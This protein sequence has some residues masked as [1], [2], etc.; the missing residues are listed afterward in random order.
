MTGT[1]GSSHNGSGNGHDKDE[2]NGKDVIEFPSLA[3]RDRIRKEKRAEEEKIRA[4]Y[5][6]QNKVPFFNVSKIPPATK[7]LFGAIFAVHILTL[8]FLDNIGQFDLIRTAGFTPGTFTGEA[9]W[10]WSALATP[11]SYIFIHSDW[12]HIGFNS[13][14]LLA[15]GVFFEREFGTRR[16]VFFFLACGLLG[17]AFYLAINPFS[18]TPVV[19]ASGSVSGL[20]GVTLL[21]MHERGA[22]GRMGRYGPW[23]LIAIW[24]FL[25]VGLGAFAGGG[26]VAWQAHLGGFLGGLFLLYLWRKKI[27]KF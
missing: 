22:M 5:R 12:M 11:F 17:A 23:P 21:M 14:M 3:Q 18:T 4:A 13:V 24:L 6:K 16:M 15:L 8:I 27:I 25:I 7:I 26:N 20:F 19:G 1:N 10:Q 9:P 2:D